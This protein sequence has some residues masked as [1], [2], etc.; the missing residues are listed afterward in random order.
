M[1]PASISHAGV[2]YDLRHL[3]QK[4][5]QF[6]WQGSDGLQF[7]FSIRVRYTDHCFTKVGGLNRLLDVDRYN[8]SLDLPAIVEE[9]FAKPT[10]PI[11]LTP[12]QNGYVFRLRMN[13]PLPNGEKYYCFLRLKRSNAYVTGE[14]PL[15]LDLFVESAH[16][17]AIAPERSKE[18]IMFGRLA[19]RLVR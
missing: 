1:L 12:E 4:I 5:F 15:K 11:Q 16:P 6:S 3:V 14:H 17:R 7:H 2:E 13:H 19:E 10:S 9:L 18:R 8:W